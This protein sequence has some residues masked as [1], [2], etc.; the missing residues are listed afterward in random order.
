MYLGFKS[1]GISQ[2]IEDFFYYR[3]LKWRELDP[4]GEVEVDLKSLSLLNDR[5]VHTFVDQFEKP[6]HF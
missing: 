5:L 4:L 6:Y 2:L 3:V 1:E